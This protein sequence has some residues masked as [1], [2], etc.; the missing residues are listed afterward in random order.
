MPEDEHKHKRLTPFGEIRWWSKDGMLKK[1]FGDFGKP[2]SAILLSVNVS[3]CQQED[4][5]A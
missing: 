1:V 4:T 3:V 5:G 2:D